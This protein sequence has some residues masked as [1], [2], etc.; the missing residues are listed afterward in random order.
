MGTRAGSKIPERPSVTSRYT[1]CTITAADNN[2]NN[3]NNG[4]L[5]GFQPGKGND[6]CVF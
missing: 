6:V 1:G 4:W 5:D 2:N 3:N